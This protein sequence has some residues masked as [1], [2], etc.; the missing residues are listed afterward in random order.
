MLIQLV[1]LLLLV[2]HVLTV[3]QVV[4]N[5]QMDLPLSLLSAYAPS[6]P[7]EMAP[8]AQTAL[9][10]LRHLVVVL[11]P[12]PQSLPKLLACVRPTST[13]MPEPAHALLALTA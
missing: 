1:L 10:T 5:P 13:V 12:V 8:P 7:T 6:T 11:V 9:L 2:L 3:A 4:L